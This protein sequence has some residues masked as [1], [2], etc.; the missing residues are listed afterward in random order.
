[1]GTFRLLQFNMQFGQVWDPA[2][3]DTAPI[4]VEDSVQTISAYDADIVMLQEVEQAREAGKQLNPPHNFSFLKHQL[5][6]YHSVFNYPPEDPRELPFGIGLAIFSRF[7]LLNQRS[8]VLPGAAI[9]FEFNGRKTSP[10]DR[11]LQIAEVDLN[12]TKV[13]LMNTH[14]QAYFMINASSDD[15]PQ[16]RDQVLAEAVAL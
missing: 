14:L 1:M 5:D 7:P 10:T 2:N 11:I 12:G 16:Q 4:R 6:G 13:T 15:Y 8:V 9:E 3:P